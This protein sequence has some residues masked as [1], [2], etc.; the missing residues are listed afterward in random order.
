[1]SS[2]QPLSRGSSRNASVCS[3]SLL[4]PKGGLVDFCFDRALP[5]ESVRVRR[6]NGK[7][8]L[9]VGLAALDIVSTCKSYP[10]EDQDIRAIS[11]RWQT[12]GNAC[13]TATVLTELGIECEF[14]GSMSRGIEADFVHKQMND[15]GV[16]H[17][18]CIR[19]SDSGTPISCVVLSLQTGS[20]TI[21]HSR[22]NLPELEV[23]DFEKLDMSKYSWIHFEGRKNEQD[24][25]KMIEIV[26]KFN[27]MHN[28]GKKIKVSVEF[29]RPRE[30]LLQL[31]SKG[32]VTFIGKDFARSRGLTSAAETVRS[33]YNKVKSGT[34]MICAWGEDGADG[35][36]P[37]G[38]AH[39]DAHHPREV[40]DTLGAGD[41]FIAGVISSLSQGLSLQ[42]ALDFACVLAGVKC[43]RQGYDGLAKALHQHS[44]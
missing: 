30:G 1:M 43:G 34:L 13:N 6:M 10:E 25:L 42:D 29:E 18:N 19:H 31:L 22:N 36:G 44:K 27:S 7:R 37:D 17:E 2:C 9:C 38:A 26:D 14:L 41:T 20:R 28:S 12:G 39:S 8:I 16:K 21:V 4:D 35:M 23:A 3:H 15:R 24:I 33:L 11:Q 40:V 5:F 32:D